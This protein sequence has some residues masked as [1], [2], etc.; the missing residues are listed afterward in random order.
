M[1]KFKYKGKFNNKVYS[2]C[3]IVPRFHATFGEPIE[4]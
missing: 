4:F 1:K 3:P 2:T